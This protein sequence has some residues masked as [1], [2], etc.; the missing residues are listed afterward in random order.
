MQ[1]GP[2]SAPICAVCH[3][4][5]SKYTCP[6]C[7]IKTCSLPCSREHKTA[8]KCSGE[9]DR[10]DFVPLKDYGYSTL[11]NDYVFL[12]DGGRKVEEWGRDIVRNGIARREEKGRAIRG[13]SMRGGSTR[14]RGRGRG[15]TYGHGQEKRNF[16]AMQLGLRDIDMEVLPSGMERARRNKSSWDSK[17]V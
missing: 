13:E 14:G 16:L 2:S 5:P 15:R 1:A 3:T 10:T 7:S 11:M 9:R 6:R 8:T 17:Y 4:Q 12:E